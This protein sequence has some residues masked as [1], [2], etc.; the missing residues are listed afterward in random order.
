MQ[1]R[2]SPT[3][4]L[5]NPFILIVAVI[6]IVTGVFFRL[7]NLDKRMFWYDETI[8]A[9]HICGSTY[10]WYHLLE[11]G[12]PVEA[13]DLLAFQV[14]NQH[15]GLKDSINSLIVLEPSHAPLYYCLLYFWAK[16]VGSSVAK[17]RLLSALISLLQIPAI[18]WLC[19]ELSGAVYL[20]FLAMPLLALSPVL[21][22]Y[23]KETREYSL[24]PLAVIVLSASF[25]RAVRK[26]DLATWTAYSLILIFALYTSP[27]TFLVLSGQIIY[28]LLQKGIRWKGFRYFLIA[29]LAAV[30][31]YAPWLKVVWDHFNDASGSVQWL[32]RPMPLLQLSQIWYTNFASPFFDPGNY[33][34]AVQ[35]LL[36]VTVLVVLYAG[37]ETCRKSPRVA[38]FLL[39]LIATNTIPFMICDLTFHWICSKPVRYQLAAIIGIIVT[40]AYLF[41]VKL[42]KSAGLQGLIWKFAF[43]LLILAEFVS[44]AICSQATTWRE[45][46]TD[47][48]CVA[49]AKILNQEPETPLLVTDESWSHNARHMLV[50]S[51]MVKPTTRILLL[52]D[53]TIP[54]LEPGTTHF[55]TYHIAPRFQEYLENTHQF[56]FSEAPDISDFKRVDCKQ[57]EH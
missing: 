43:C 30:V 15:H 14:P 49:V 35:L 8:S 47:S 29:C 5:K 57:I 50:I 9:N 27:I 33:C 45:L 54:K 3:H 40:V 10:G 31:T 38:K 11:K 56:T 53:P 44:C 42:R 52:K 25:L 6:A 20:G 18:F 2:R 24:F 17:L 46:S 55:Y 39:V 37:F 13:I 41:Y 1:N 16:F 22:I 23:A 28:I 48:N 7:Y 19:F 21:V 4:N 36:G 51:H 34:L 26:Q 12:E 32:W